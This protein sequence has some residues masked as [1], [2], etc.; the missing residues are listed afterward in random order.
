MAG[1]GMSRLIPLLT[2]AAIVTLPAS[3]AANDPTEACRQFASAEVIFVGR[4]NGAPITRRVSGEEDI[5]KA[6]VVKEAAERELKAFEA[7][8]MPPEIGW[9][10]HMDL[11]VRMVKASDEYGRVRAMHPPPVDFPVTPLLVE[12][13]FRGVTTKELFMWN[14][15]QPALD[16]ARSYLFFAERPAGPLAPEIVF[17][18]HPKEVEAAEA[19]LQFL[20]EAVANNDGTTVRGSLNFQDPDDQMRR[21]PMPGVALRVFL[22]GQRYESSTGPDGTFLITGVPPGLLRIE[23]VLPEHLTLPPQQ[24]GGM[25]KGGCLDVHMRA[26][27]NGR[28]RGRV[29]LDSGEPFRGIVDL[30]RQGH[31]RVVPDSTKF[32]NDRGE[33]SFA[34]VP[35]GQYL[36]GINVSRQPSQGAPYAPTYFPGTTDKSE[37]TPVVVG[38]GTEH[39][40]IDWVVN[41]KLPE[42][43]IEV[44]LDSHGQVQKEMGVCVTM[45]DADNRNTGGVG[46]ERRSAEPVVVKVV[47]GVRYRLVAW[48][49]TPSG[50]AESDIFDVIGTPGRQ[51]IKLAVAST[52]EKAMGTR[53]SWSNAPFS[54]S[55]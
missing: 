27:F 41:S 43:G 21:T 39:A 45:F 31:A 28:I 54:P 7:L 35:P 36:L 42:G 13:A 52:S 32:T 55:R 26:T 12:T 25:A 3:A 14:R 50:F 5:E 30:V 15:G 6:R 34:A 33:F 47:E 11:T 37:A 10:R 19:D 24:N 40:E 17:A 4:V 48:A 18:A 16:P 8:K 38:Q 23:P 9:Q 20:R 44:T 51:V 22:D 49:R 46:Y 2:V 1:T 53:C 29:L